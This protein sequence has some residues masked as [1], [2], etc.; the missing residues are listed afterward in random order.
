MIHKEMITQH[1]EKASTERASHMLTF[2]TLSVADGGKVAD[3]DGAR[4]PTYTA[5]PAGN[6]IPPDD[7]V[8]ATA[9]ASQQTPCS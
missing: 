1:A 8:S 9:A 7:K 6:T 5:T 2:P 4:I 3:T